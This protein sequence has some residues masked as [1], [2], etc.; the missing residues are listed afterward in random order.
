MPSKQSIS[1][2]SSPIRNTT[3]RSG[4]VVA[5]R[6]AIDPRKYGRLLARTL[7]GIIETK[8]EY[9]RFLTE[10]EKLIDQ[11]K[12][13]PE[14]DKLLDLITTLVEKFEEKNYPIPTRLHTRLL[15][16]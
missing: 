1:K 9:E 3:K 16:N 10:I 4:K 8:S 13:S 14:E 5:A 12:R 11:E 6:R 15:E 7:P 2:T